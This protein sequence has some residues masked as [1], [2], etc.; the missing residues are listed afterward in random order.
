MTVF[1]DTTL[2]TANAKNAVILTVWNVLTDNAINANCTTDLISIMNAKSALITANT[3]MV[4]LPNAKNVMKDII[5]SMVNAT[6]AL[7]IVKSVP[8]TLA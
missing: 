3:V 6:N 5:I 1:K 8:M 4:I 2:V 7:K